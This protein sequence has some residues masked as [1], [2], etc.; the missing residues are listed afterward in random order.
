MTVVALLRTVGVYRYRLLW[1]RARDARYRTAFLSGGAL[2][3]LLAAYLVVTASTA[4]YA[5]VRVAQSITVVTIILTVVFSAAIAATITIG[6]GTRRAFSDRMLRRFPITARRRLLVVHATGLVEPFW[7][8]VILL[9]SAFAAALVAAGA[10][11]SGYAAL[12]ALLFLLCTYTAA[13]VAG[14]LADRVLASPRAS[15]AAA[16]LVLL[17][18]VTLP[19]VARRDPAKTTAA[20]GAIGRVMPAGIA[21]RVMTGTTVAGVAWDALALLAWFG[22]LTQAAASLA[23]A[24]RRPAGA[25]GP[26][27]RSRAIDALGACVV[28]PMSA[29]A[30]KVALYHLRSLRLRVS[31]ALVPVVAG[32]VASG[33]SHSTDRFFVTLATFFLAGTIGNPIFVFNQ[34]AFDGSG[35]RRYRRWPVPFRTALRAGSAVGVA[36]G[37]VFVPL[38]LAAVMVVSPDLSATALATLFGAGIAGTAIFHAAGVVTSVAWPGASRFDRVRGTQLPYTSALFVFSSVGAVFVGAGLLSQWTALAGSWQLAAGVWSVA[39]LGA[40][41]YAVVWTRGTVLAAPFAARCVNLLV[42]ERE[43]P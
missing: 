38:A 34:F 29:I 23:A 24:E 17:A 11:G 32:F 35:V 39:V 12:G 25:R 13:M 16:M 8:A 7:L 14:G 27:A 43:A 18:A 40:L 2:W 41:I 36:A 42:A 28:G 10:C 31:L 1:A 6:A 9:V 20:A 26:V 19:Y 30:T 5:A 21:A 22:L 15:A 3:L 4:A 33:A 37:L